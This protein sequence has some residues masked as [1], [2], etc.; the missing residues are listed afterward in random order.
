[1]PEEQAGEGRPSRGGGGT[2]RTSWRQRGTWMQVLI[3]RAATGGG[4]A[5]HV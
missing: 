4:S 2:C 1:M 3:Q 5:D